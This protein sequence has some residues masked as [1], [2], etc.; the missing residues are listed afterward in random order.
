MI[1][2]SKSGKFMSMGVALSLGWFVLEACDCDETKEEQ[3]PGYWVACVG[4]K[5]TLMTYNGNNPTAVTSDPAG[6]FNPSQWDCSTPGSP[7]RSKSSSPAFPSGAPS[8][9]GGFSVKNPAAT[10]PA[11]SAATPGTSAYNPQPL[12]DLPFI[13]Q[14]PLPAPQQCDSS[15]PDVFQT[16]HTQAL[17]TR[18]STCPFAVKATIPVQTRPLQVEITPDGS[19]AIVTSFDN[20]VNFIDVATNKVTFTFNTD[21]LINPNGIAISPDG[22]K[23]YVSSFNTNFPAVIVIDIATHQLLATMQTTMPYPSGL[24]LTPDGSQIWVAAPLANN[25]DIFDTQTNTRVTTLNIGYA[26]QVAFNSVGTRAYITSAAT[27]PGKVIVVNATTYQ[28]LSSFMVGANPT[29]IVMSYGDR[30]LV[31]NNDADGSIS[32]I[33]LLKNKV[34]T[35]AIGPNPSG[36][37]FVH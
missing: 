32:V 20:A 11:V 10:R 17:V 35:A 24:T 31:V 12:R 3:F 36:I 4:N 13:P 8:G 14:M 37:A 5:P 25:V 21:P 18:V 19:T 30:F 27:T 15:Y 6:N 33:D 28:V 7:P 2:L 26:T 1:K 16:V 22:T 34:Q 29:D 23:V 9:P